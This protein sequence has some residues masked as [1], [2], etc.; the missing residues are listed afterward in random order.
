MLLYEYDKSGNFVIIFGSI[1]FDN[2]SLY[3]V[4]DILSFDS[5][6]II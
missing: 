6:P 2:G 4:S 5:N 1:F 3:I